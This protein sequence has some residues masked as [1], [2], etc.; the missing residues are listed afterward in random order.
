[1]IE[2]AL[3]LSV[4]DREW[5]AQELWESLEDEPIDPELKAVLDRRWEEI[6]SGKVKTIPHEQVMAEM[7]KILNEVRE[8]RVSS[9]N[10]D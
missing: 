5:I 8:N 9:G 6:E 10:K 4:E 1:M 7:S 3:K 2:Q